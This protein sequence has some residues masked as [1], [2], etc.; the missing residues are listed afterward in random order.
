MNR[1]TSWLWAEPENFEKH[2]R[3]ITLLG[4]FCVAWGIGTSLLLIYGGV[5]LAEIQKGFSGIPT[6]LFA[7]TNIT[8]SSGDIAVFAGV[9]EIIFRLMIFA[10]IIFVLSR[11]TNFGDIMSAVLPIAVIGSIL[12]GLA[13]GHWYNVLIQGVYGLAFS[14]IYLKCGGL[15]GKFLTGTFCSTAA[16]AML[17]TLMFLLAALAA[18]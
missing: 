5:S 3:L 7:Q 10:P 16:H 6:S 8:L 13:H 4:I 1:L 14:A 2:L 15:R 18:N 11:R 9:E 17:N 12:F